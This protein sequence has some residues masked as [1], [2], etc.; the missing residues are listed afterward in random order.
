[1][2]AIPPASQFEM[3]PAEM[4]S[5]IWDLRRSLA[6]TAALLAER[7]NDRGGGTESSRRAVAEARTAL[8][9][10]PR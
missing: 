7:D 5:Y 9:K 4:M 3:N 1:M 8:E 6:V 2:N 10:L